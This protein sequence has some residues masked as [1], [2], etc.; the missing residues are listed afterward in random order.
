MLFTD[1][2]K[3]D[4]QL[5][6]A[7][8]C[9][10]W[11]CSGIL[12]FLI[13]VY[14]S[15]SVIMIRPSAEINLSALSNRTTTGP[16]SSAFLKDPHS[17]DAHGLDSAESIRCIAKD[18]STIDTPLDAFNAETQELRSAFL[19]CSERSVWTFLWQRLQHLFT[20]ER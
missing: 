2:H 12:A 10:I 18:G 16:I 11:L 19:V 20:G 9:A 6:S 17:L 3:A 7:K 4:Y 15:L 1:V 13:L 14:C 5:W 8:R